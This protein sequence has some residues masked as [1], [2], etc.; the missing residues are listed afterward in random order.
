M[1]PGAWLG[2]ELLLEAAD[3]LVVSGLG[4]LAE[5]LLGPG[6]GLAQAAVE[7]AQ[8]V[9]QL[10]LLGVDGLE[11][12]VDLGLLLDAIPALPQAGLTPPPLGLLLLRLSGLAEVLAPRGM[13]V[14][15]WCLLAGVGFAGSRLLLRPGQ[16]PAG[17][18]VTEYLL[19][20]RQALFG[21]PARLLLA[22]RVLRR[23]QLML[24]T[25]NARHELP[26]IVYSDFVVQ[27]KV[28]KVIDWSRK[29]RKLRAEVDLLIVWDG[30]T[31]DRFL[32]VTDVWYS[33]GDLLLRL[34]VLQ[35]VHIIEVALQLHTLRFRH[36]EVELSRVLV[37]IL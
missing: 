29:F 25:V 16:R 37:G 9:F 17:P 23:V 31:I 20:V 3:G 24:S 30:H 1:P 22:E 13:A 4:W 11:V 33:G 15:L 27:V 36:L 35:L 7:L 8:V 2:F 12:P 14:D 18:L 32:D 19:D 34:E 10:Q 21:L 28:C 5:V 26:A 6:C